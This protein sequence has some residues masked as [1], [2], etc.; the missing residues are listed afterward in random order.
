MERGNAAERRLRPG[1]IDDAQWRCAAGP[2]AER[3]HPDRG[4]VRARLKS[5]FLFQRRRLAA[6]RKWLRFQRQRSDGDWGHQRA[7]ER[8]WRHPADLHRRSGCGQASG[9]RRVLERTGSEPRGREI[10]AGAVSTGRVHEARDGRKSFGRPRTER[11][12]V[13]SNCARSCRW[14][15]PS[16]SRAIFPSSPLEDNLL[17][18]AFSI[19][20][21]AV[22]VAWL[23][24]GARLPAV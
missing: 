6:V 7:N 14:L 23:S 22:L 2:P 12:S 19:V 16:R 9:R 11:R 21:G 13:Q 4:G 8:S 24:R 20:L 1:G 10:S 17:W 15:V 18:I 5:G 3:R